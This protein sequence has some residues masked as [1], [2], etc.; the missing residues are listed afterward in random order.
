MKAQFLDA[1]YN[2][3]HVYLVFFV[4]YAGSHVFSL[5]LSGGTAGPGVSCA[6]A[7]QSQLTTNQ[8]T[9]KVVSCGGSSTIPASN[10]PVPTTTAPG[11]SKTPKEKV[12]NLLGARRAQCA[13]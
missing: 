11:A 6:Q 13:A 1:L 9:V 12:T 8:V 10:T 2:Q 5:A 3:Q 7:I 4:A